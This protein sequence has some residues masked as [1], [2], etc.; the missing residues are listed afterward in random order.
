MYKKLII[1]I[2]IFILFIGIAEV[3]AFSPSGNE[4]YEGIDISAWQGS[5]NFNN[6]TAQGI[7]IVYMKASQ[8]TNYIDPYLENYYQ[9]AKSAGLKVGFYHYLTARNINEA[10]AEA[11][12]FVNA[13]SGKSPDC[14]LAMDFESFGD[15]SVNEI[16][17]IAQNFLQT[18]EKLTNKN[19]I[20][21][22]DDYNAGNVFS[23]ALSIYP[24]WVA[25]YDVYE[26]GSNVNWE[27]WAGFQYTDQGSIEGIDGYVDRDKFTNDIFLSDTTQILE[28]RNNS[29]QNTN[30]SIVIQQGETL[31]G[32]AYKYGTTVEELVQLNNIQNPNLIY[33]GNTL[34][35]PNTTNTT[36]ISKGI[37]MYTIQRGN[38]LS[39]IARRY[40]TTVQILTELNNI[41]NPNLIY[42][43]NVIKIPLNSPIETNDTGHILYTVQRG[44]YLS[45]IARKYHVTVRQIVILNQIQNPNLIYPGQILRI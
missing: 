10:E 5:I 34:L 26:P 37:I 24:L 25:D 9:D 41:Q 1:L 28:L 27:S 35:V 44:D 11:N 16:N 29:E 18:V 23:S 45:R 31:S 38:T 12:F 8:G 21:Y 14:L 43:G 32:I 15:L 4:M 7:E 30:Y 39:G 22:S 40:G 2:T 42:S 3:K 33:V 13:I 19:T 20:I 6:V 36:S 17:Q